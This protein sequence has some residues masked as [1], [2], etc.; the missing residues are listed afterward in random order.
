[1]L[2]A[3]S[4]RLTQGR[5]Q[6]ASLLTPSNA[7]DLQ[8]LTAEGCLAALGIPLGRVEI[9]R[10]RDPFS[11]VS[12]NPPT[13]CGW[14]GTCSISNEKIGGAS[15]HPK[16]YA[17]VAVLLA[18]LWANGC[19][20]SSTQSATASNSGEQTPATQPSANGAAP[21]TNP[22]SATAPPTIQNSQAAQSEAAP[23]V[24]HPGGDTDYGS[25]SEAAFQCVGGA[26]GAI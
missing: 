8:S 9:A 17:I 21:D 20:K 26:G 19:H 25:S 22:A 2:S 10:R 6:I 16:R 3:K 5:G 23:K 18:L 24:D 15:M 14:H 12:R 4:T 1:M 13:T 7:P 11:Y